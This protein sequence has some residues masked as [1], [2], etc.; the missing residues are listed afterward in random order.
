MADQIIL[1]K[2]GTVS[3][4]GTPQELMSARQKAIMQQAAMVGGSSLKDS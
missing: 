4:S 2:A 3:F 1:M